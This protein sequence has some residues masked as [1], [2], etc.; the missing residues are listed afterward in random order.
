MN[1]QRFQTFY[2]KANEKAT[3]TYAELIDFYKNWTKNLQQ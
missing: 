1:A 2:E 3:A